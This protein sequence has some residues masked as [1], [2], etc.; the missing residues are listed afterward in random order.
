MN[1]L[2]NMKEMNEE[3]VCR[4]FLKQQQKRIHAPDLRTT[5]SMM[6]KRHAQLLVRFIF[7]A[8]VKDKRFIRLDPASTFLDETLVL[9]AERPIEVDRKFWVTG[10]FADHLTPFLRT[11]HH[12]TRLPERILWE[13]IAVRVNSFFRKTMETESLTCE[14]EARALELYSLLENAEPDSFGATVHPLKT[15]LVPKNQLTSMQT[16]KTCCHFYR[17]EKDKEMDYCLVCPLKK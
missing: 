17:L 5:A 15:Y 8:Y 16:R 13:N 7:A 4:Q 3:D 9:N 1:K 12:F 10:I 11:L 2:W 14:E 6:M